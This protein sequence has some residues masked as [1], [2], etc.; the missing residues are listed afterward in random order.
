MAQIEELLTLAKTLNPN[1]E[2]ALIISQI[3]AE[4][5]A[6]DAAGEWEKHNWEHQASSQLQEIIEQ[7]REGASK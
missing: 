4:L 6:N 5:E 7:M 2:Q 3:Q 1:C